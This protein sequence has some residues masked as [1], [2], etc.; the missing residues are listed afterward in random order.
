MREQ[1]DSGQLV[2]RQMTD[3]VHAGWKKRQ[4]EFDATATTRERDRRDN[5]LKKRLQR[6]ARLAL[7]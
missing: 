6:N 4:L 5:A 1:M 7:R 2:I 3:D